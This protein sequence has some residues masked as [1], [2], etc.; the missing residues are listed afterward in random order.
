MSSGYFWRQTAKC[1]ADTLEKDVS[2]CKGGCVGESS[3]KAFDKHEN[4]LL[5]NWEMSS[6]LILQFILHV[7]QFDSPSSCSVD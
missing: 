5:I 6:L 7:N 1:Y 3:P 2:F 4:G